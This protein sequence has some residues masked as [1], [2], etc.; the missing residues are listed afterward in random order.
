MD[1]S[2]CS[3]KGLT[4]L[5]ILPKEI[6]P[7]LFAFEHYPDAEGEGEHEQRPEVKI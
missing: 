4:S 7:I 2:Q 3:R 1:I 6:T 5:V